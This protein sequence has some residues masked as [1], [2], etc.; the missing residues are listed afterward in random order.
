[1]PCDT[2]VIFPGMVRSHLSVESACS[3]PDIKFDK[4][5]P[6]D[7]PPSAHA[8]GSG[9]PPKRLRLLKSNSS[10]GSEPDG[11]FAK[12]TQVRPV[13]MRRR[14]GQ[15]DLPAAIRDDLKGLLFFLHFFLVVFLLLN[16]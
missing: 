2:L 14:L 4:S 6:R 5:P 1:M 12:M 15:H 16:Q 9:P 7:R 3:V 8:Q 11:V 10:T 13:A